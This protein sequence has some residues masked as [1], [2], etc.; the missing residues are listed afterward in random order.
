MSLIGS[1]IYIDFPS[2]I[3]ALLSRFISLPST[4]SN[5]TGIEFISCILNNFKQSSGYWKT[6]NKLKKNGIGAFSKI[7]YGT[8]RYV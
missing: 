3:I 7:W 6:L 8:K 2:M 1:I 4:L 5:L